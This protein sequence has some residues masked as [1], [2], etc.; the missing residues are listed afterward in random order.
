[1]DLSQFMEYEAS[2]NRLADRLLETIKSSPLSGT[3][4]YLETGELLCGVQFREDIPDRENLIVLLKER[5][6][7]FYDEAKYCRY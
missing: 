1:M 5:G 2:V 7:E 3:G 4:E 6:I